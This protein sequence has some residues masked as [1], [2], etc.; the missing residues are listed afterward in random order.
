MSNDTTIQSVLDGDDVSL[1]ELG[2][3]FRVLGDSTRIR[4]ISLLIPSELCV[5]DIAD[6]IGMSESAVSHQ[7]RILRQAKMV[8]TRREGKQVFY[9]LDDD[10]I[11]QLVRIGLA[12]VKEGR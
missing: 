5:Q 1:Y 3:F 4:I 2:D 6:S 9:A 8:R 12:H 11:E 10:H 7:L